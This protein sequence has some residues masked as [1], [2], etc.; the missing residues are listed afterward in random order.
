MYRLD[1]SHERTLR[2]VFT[3]TAGKGELWIATSS[4]NV[5][6]AGGGGRRGWGVVRCHDYT[7]IR[8]FR[9]K[10]IQQLK[11]AS[12]KLKSEASIIALWVCMSN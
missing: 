6:C 1:V 8:G 3:Q 7:I 4:C 2:S 11:V 10:L 12:I 5:G 9:I